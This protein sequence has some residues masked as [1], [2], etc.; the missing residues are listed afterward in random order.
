MSLRQFKKLK[1]TNLLQ[2]PDQLK[3]E[4]TDEENEEPAGPVQ[5]LNP[6][7][8]LRDEEN[9]PTQDQESDPENLSGG[10]HADPVPA[11]SRP[12]SKP[13]KKKKKK[14]KQ[15]PKVEE[16][17]DV[18]AAIRLVNQKLGKLPA[19]VEEQIP[20]TSLNLDKHPILSIDVKLL[21]W[22]GEMKRNFGAGVVAGR[23][24]EKSRLPQRSARKRSLLVTPKESWPRV[25]GAPGLSMIVVDEYSQ[26]YSLSHSKSY[27]TFELMFYQCIATHNP[28]MLYN[29]LKEYPFHICS[30]L[31]LSE[32]FKQ[33]GDVAMAGD[34][35]ERVL[36]AFEC[37]FHPTF[38]FLGKCQLNFNR[39]ETR[40]VF[41]AL[42]RH[43]QY[44]SRRGCWR[45]AL[46]FAKF[47]FSL[48]STN[49]PLAAVLLLDFYALRS[50]SFAWMVEF[51]DFFKDKK[52]LDH[53]PS[54]C[55]SIALAHWEL[56]TQSGS[57]HSTSTTLLDAAIEKFPTV[58]VGLLRKMAITDPVLEKSAFFQSPQSNAALSRDTLAL[59]IDM[60]V[61]SAHPMW[62]VPE[63]LA[64][65]RK[66]A[67]H[68]ANK[69]S[70]P[71]RQPPAIGDR[72]ACPF[73][74]GDMLPINLQRM[75]VLADETTFI[76]RLPEGVMDN[77]MIFDPFP[78]RTAETSA[79]DGVRDPSLLEP[80]GT[81]QGFLNYLFNL[82]GAG[83]IDA[84]CRAR[85]F[86]PKIAKLL[87]LQATIKSLDQNKV[88]YVI[89]DQVRVEPTDI[90][91]KHAV[92]FV[93]QQRPDA[94]IAV[95]G[96]SV[97]DTAKAANLYLAHPDAEF[98][99]FVNVP[100]TAGTGSE[101]TGTS[102]FDYTPKKFKTGIAFR[103]LKPLLGLVDPYNTRSMA[104]EVHV[105]T[106]LDVL[107][108]SLESYTA[109]P[110]TE[111][112][113]RPTNPK[114]R[115]AYQGSN[116]ISDIWSL[117]SLKMCID[118][119]PRAYRDAGD[120]EAQEQMILAATFAGIG[121]GNA[122]VHLCHGMSYPIS[123]LNKKYRHPGYNT[124][125]PLVPHGIS[126]ALSSPAV[127]E[128][129]APTDP[130]RHLEC[131]RLFGVDTSNV[132]REDAGKVL[133]DALRKFLYSID[134]PNGLGAIGFHNS[135]IEKLVLG[136]LPQLAQKN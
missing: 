61:E 19:A 22:E 66:T 4:D 133:A 95:G 117:R 73:T 114:F 113:P 46:E 134:V 12:A 60:Y 11:D 132:K 33:Q 103:Q 30:L 104:P 127:F 136:T 121:F 78:P 76:S 130:E 55:Y 25:S 51:W 47:L 124:E 26:V 125:F 97:I 94:F 123:G 7:D 29:V 65:L 119:L 67:G 8:L 10:N 14:P 52:G 38:N 87:P 37:S 101:T 79:Y 15:K 71:A 88:N 106:G 16:D 44:L 21:D 18:D 39:I 120:H 98:L 53:L 102:I 109:I 6:F 96:G 24:K 110:Y 42:F 90:S 36:Y 72:P 92:D 82:F 40:P 64:W 49:D 135:D 131:A 112:S 93:R 28:D 122:G 34:F 85:W 48:D 128:Y 116:P 91:I 59:L 75:V 99:D 3:P 54:A 58:V 62:K 56:E 115:P 41:V 83:G 80:Q 77:L 105:S 107:C 69:P 9:E 45:T 84:V 43:I 50:G 63:I 111:R 1:E 17:D 81:G 126:V 74:P 118:N 32:V 129:T 108:H 100:T 86:T 68:V 20:Q 31:Q 70:R 5:R 89:Y 2:P 57:N 13:Q 23:D 27:E 35:I